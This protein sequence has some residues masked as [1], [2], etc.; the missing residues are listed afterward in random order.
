MCSMIQLCHAV[1]IAACV[2]P[3][4]GHPWAESMLHNF[5]PCSILARESRV[6]NIRHKL[7]TSQHKLVKRLTEVALERS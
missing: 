4:I 6:E 7:G 1:E 3:Q 5:T 2:C